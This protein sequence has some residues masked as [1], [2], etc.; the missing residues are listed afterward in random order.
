MVEQLP[1]QQ[2]HVWA[3]AALLVVHPVAM[4]QAASGPPTGEILRWAPCT[5]TCHCA[6]KHASARSDAHKTGAQ[7]YRVICSVAA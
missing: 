5:S 4:Q 6:N 1:L 3:V 2:L 7:A